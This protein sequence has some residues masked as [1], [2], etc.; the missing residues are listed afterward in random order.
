MPYREDL[1]AAVARADAAE[2]KIA[3][4]TLNTVSKSEYEK[5]LS[6]L[7][8]ETMSGKTIFSFV[9]MILILLFSIAGATAVGAH[10]KLSIYGMIGAGA[11]T[12]T[13]VLM[14]EAAL[15]YAGWDDLF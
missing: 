15:V 3:D 2:M 1:D 12:G 11:I 6:K 9:A 7:E 13:V 4:L 5:L 10:Y 8:G 14:I